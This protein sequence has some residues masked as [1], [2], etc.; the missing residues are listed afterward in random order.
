[1]NM[2]QLDTGGGGTGKGIGFGILIRKIFLIDSPAPPVP[3]YTIP[4]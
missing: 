4:T 3:C 1:M 2:N